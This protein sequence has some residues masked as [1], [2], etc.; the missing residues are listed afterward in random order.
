MWMA[1]GPELTFFCNDAY[2]RDTLGTKYPWAL[3]RRADE[4]WEE[5]WP[6]IGP[7]IEQVMRTGAATWDE[8]L[9][10]FLER[11]GFREETYHTFSYSP[12]RDDDGTIAGMLCVVSEESVRVIGERRM[13]TLRELGADPIAVR[14]EA[15]AI[16]VACRHL[17]NNVHSLPF[18]LTYL[19]DEDGQTARLAGTSGISFGHPAAPEV[20][21]RDDPD[22]LWPFKDL[23]EG[24]PK[25]LELGGRSWTC[26]R[27]PGRSRR[28]TRCSSISPTRAR[29]SR[30][31]SSS[32]RSIA[33]RRSRRATGRTCRSSR[34]RWRRAS[35]APGPT[36]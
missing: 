3:G 4:V 35:R 12:L 20:L 9:L 7:R 10:L 26:R 32:R 24:M 8:A 34:A 22:P 19:F 27:A 29:R 11:G 1:W 16:D 13:A 36:T 33:T 17:A 5:I 18:T 21:R 25:L 6:D 31:A 28:C 30:S 23:V 14:T 15:V 2:R